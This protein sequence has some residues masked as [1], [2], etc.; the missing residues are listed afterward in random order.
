MKPLSR[1]ILLFVAGLLLLGALFSAFPAAGQKPE[2]ISAGTLAERVQNG[3]VK[4]I[5]VAGNEVEATMQDGAKAVTRKE[6]EQSVAELLTGYGVTPDE[7]KAAN[8]TVKDKSGRAYLFGVVL[9]SLLPLVVLVALFF[10]MIKQMQGA[11]NRAMSFGQSGAREAVDREKP[12]VTFKDVA[13]AAEAK[14]ELEEIVEFLKHPKKFADLGAKLPKGVLLMG[15]PG[16]GKTLLARAVSGE[17]RVPFFH[18][19]GS[20]FVEMFVGVGASRVRDLFARAKKSAPCIIFIDEIDAVGRQRGAGLGGSHDEREQTL[21]QILVEMDGFDP[22]IG[23]IVIAATNRPD[24]LD[25]ALLRPGRFDRR[26][27]IDLPDVKDREAILKVHAAN[28]PLAKGLELKRVAQRT[29]G[30]SG[31][32]LMNL[33]NEAAI[34]AARHDAKEV[35]QEDVLDSIEKVLLGPERRSHILSDK[36]KKVTAYHEA[37]HALVA[38]L[39]PDADPV[40]KVSIVSRG[41]AGGYTLKLPD[42]DRRMHRRAEFLDDLAVM[43]GGYVSEKETF[44]DLTTGAS[45]DLK[46][47]NRL[48]RD[49]VTRYGMSEEL[50]PQVFGEAE[51]MVFLGRDLHE[52]RNYSEKTAERIDLEVEKLIRGAM[53]KARAI[54]RG[55]KARLDKIVKVLLEKETIEKEEFENLLEKA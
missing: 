28:K 9:P 44:G 4:E 35:T 51:E 31:A 43:L 47:C 52:T 40:H 38:H 55:D 20:E 25:P 54:I 23:V 50:G 5:A 37:G 27:V 39:L 48:A 34:R 1:N 30:F 14:E 49:L 8:V 2:E 18:I 36:E 21:N 13:G 19:S 7:L 33:L 42:E 10:F 12:R 53:D 15:R 3:S 16:T 11:N 29:V 41:S 17:A 6:S 24:V 32:D 26:V 45:D 22:N 46:K